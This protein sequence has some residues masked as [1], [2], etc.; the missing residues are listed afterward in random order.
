MPKYIVIYGGTDLDA[1]QVC[2]V[3]QVANR[4]LSYPDVVLLTGGFSHYA[5]NPNGRSVDRVVLDVAEAQLSSSD[6]ARRFETWLP[7][8]TLEREPAIRF[9]KGKVCELFGTP[10]AR[11]YKVIQRASGIV[12]IGGKSHTRSVLELAL[13]VGKPALPIPF[14]GGQSKSMW[15]QNAADFVSSLRTNAEALESLE[16]TP[17]TREAL[18]SAA[19]LAVDTLLNAVERRCLVLMPFDSIHDIF[20][21]NVLVPAIRG[22]DF[23][24]YRIDRDEHAGDI[25]TIFSR[26]LDDSQVIVVDLTDFNP[27]VLYELGW[28]HSRARS[29]MLLLRYSTDVGTKLGI[30]FYLL[31]EKVLMVP[32]T[33]AGY[34]QA[35]VDVGRYLAGIRNTQPRA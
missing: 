22:E 5:H 7:A 16:H 30:P 3:E 31:H 8:P 12:C 6:F 21:A 20:Y 2:L 14:T 35:R 23:V 10:Q 27:N 17:T 29:A 19:N 11:R 1:E 24:P 9:R 34:G 15:E 4:C 28:L 32:S 13:A 18:L 26:A 25:P 33:E